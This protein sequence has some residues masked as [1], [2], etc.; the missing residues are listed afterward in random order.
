M[1]NRREQ[2][3]LTVPGS[4]S[5]RRGAEFGNDTFFALDFERVLDAVEA[6]GLSCKPVCFALNS[7]ENRVYDIE[8]TSGEHVVAKFYRPGRW[9]REQI[10]EEHAFLADL[11]AAE[12]PVCGVMTLPDGGTLATIEG[13]HYCLAPRRGGRAPQDIDEALAERL[14]MLLARIHLVGAAKPAPHRPVLDA[15]SMI[16]QSLAWLDSRR[17]IPAA[18]RPRYAAAATALATRA[19]EALA[20]LPTHRVHGDFHLGNLLVRDEV[21]HVLDFDDMVTGPAGQDVWM[22]WGG[23]GLVERAA[24][25]DGY[26]QFRRFD[27]RQ[28]DAIGAFRGMRLVRYACWLAQRWHDPVFPLTWPHFGTEEYWA[29]E[30][31]SLEEALVESSAEPDREPSSAEG[32]AELTNRDF[33]WD[34]EGDA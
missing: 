25:V 24:F 17:V 26:E 19:D 1:A 13:I 6:C 20:G 12:V 21:L 16:R 14:G 27:A 30:A 29:R 4:F 10:L 5:D 31:Q 33:F 11:E 23:L 9:S 15:Q 8:L 3:D 32:A 18:L 7:Y 28:L 2:P 22:L 34:W